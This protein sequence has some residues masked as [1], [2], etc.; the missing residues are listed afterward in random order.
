MSTKIDL[1]KIETIESPRTILEA[2][3]KSLGG[4]LP[5]HGGWG[6]SQNDACKCDSN[7]VTGDSSVSFLCRL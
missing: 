5:I 1:P 3:F 6:Y 7:I 4:E 2:H